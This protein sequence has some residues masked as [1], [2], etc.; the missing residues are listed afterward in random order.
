MHERLLCVVPIVGT[1]TP[2]DPR[3]PMFAPLPGARKAVENA[4]DSPAAEGII[5]FSFEESDDGRYALVEFVA[6][7]RA[8]FDRITKDKSSDIKVFRE[9]KDQRDEI[10]R[11]FRKHKRSFRLDRPGVGAL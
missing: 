7:D 3:R 8:A 1:G 9:D 4:D 6:R 11:E 2:D 10:E 5:A